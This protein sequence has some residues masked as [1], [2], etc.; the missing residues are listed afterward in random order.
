M[1]VQPDQSACDGP[2]PAPS[3]NK[4]KRK[5][6][7]TVGHSPTDNDVTPA[8]PLRQHDGDGGDEEVG[9]GVLVPGVKK[10]AKKPK[11]PSTADPPAEKR[12]RRFRPKAPSSFHAVY[13]RATTQRF[14]LL[15]RTRSGT[16]DCPEELFELT[17]STGNI[18]RVHIQ[19]Q[20]TCSCPHGTAGNQCKHI[21][22]CLKSILRA[23]DAHVYQLALLSTELRDIF[24]NAPAPTSESG[25]EKDK[26]RKAVEGDCPICFEEMQAG[27]AKEPL[28]WCK[29]ACGQNIHKECFEMWAATKKTG[30]GVGRAVVSCPYCRSAW[31]GDNDM[32]NKINTSGTPNPDGYVN[33]ADQLGISTERDY[34]AYST[35]WTGHP[36]YR[37][38]R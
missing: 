5:R 36:G 38:R 21:V 3:D 2:P 14:F 37:G 25:P 16:A 12:L 28:V 1:G 26:N 23:P 32:I 17:G 8:A 7:P 20:P 29:A 13:E 9:S 24:A 33:V 11:D 6:Q 15:S 27:D 19:K 22:W 30:S 4:R 31:E 10:K 35:W 18:Y 34:S